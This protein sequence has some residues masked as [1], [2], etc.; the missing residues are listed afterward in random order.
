MTASP[1]GKTALPKA[2][3]DKR[4]G[5]AAVSR[6]ATRKSTSQPLLT[7]PAGTLTKPSFILWTVALVGV[8][9]FAFW[10]TLR[11]LESEWRT[12]ADYSHGYVVIPLSL[13]LLWMRWDSFPG[14][15]RRADWRGL[16]LIGLGIAMRV[17][18]R[19]AYMDFMD[20]WS[21]VPLVAGIV[22]LL[23]GWP[24]TRWAAPAILFL[25]MLVP[26]PY[27]AESMLSW[28]LQ[29][30]ATSISTAM[31]R[32]LGKPAIAEGHTIWVG[33]TQLMIEQACSGLRIFVG[34]IALAFFWAATVTRSWLDRVVILAA[35]L[36]MAL[37]V[38]SL[39]ITAT[40]CLYGWFDSPESRHIIHDWTGYLM[41]PLAAGLLWCVKNYWER[42]YRPIAI[43]NPAERLREQTS[44]A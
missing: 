26:L 16:S 29:G 2:K 25:F 6:A 11:W 20:G 13:I 34:M 9:A 33:E 3:A 15:S 32:I 22:W 1:A 21:I 44:G 28:K 40:G 43:H 31:L 8:F 7:I 38:N 39:R 36:P 42:V 5:K 18:G 10:P 4:P 24:A 37:L 12:E 30:I 35:A 41:I 27:R 23:F 17:V 19:L 14:L